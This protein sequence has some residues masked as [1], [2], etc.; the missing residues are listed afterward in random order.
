MWDRSGRVSRAVG[1]TAQIS[2][3][4][5]CSV[6]PRITVQKKELDVAMANVMKR[7][8]EK[9]NAL[10]FHLSKISG[11]G[12]SRF[13]D[14]AAPNE[15]F[16]LVNDAY[17]DFLSLFLIPRA[18]Y[19]NGL[20]DEMVNYAHGEFRG[21]V[22]RDVFESDLFEN[23]EFLYNRLDS[24]FL[25]VD[26]QRVIKDLTS[27]RIFINLIRKMDVNTSVLSRWLPAWFRE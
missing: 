6:A 23:M 26:D 9:A 27:R 19:P 13:E 11:L 3:E 18:T 20:P 10:K 8:V 16:V 25:I 17:D 15:D 4:K 5:A 21:V 24:Y 14:Y 1:V 22:L 2:R 7:A 12:Q